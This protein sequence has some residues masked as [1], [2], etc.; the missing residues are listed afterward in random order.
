[1]AVQAHSE[2][3]EIEAVTIEAVRS[4]LEPPE[5]PCLSVYLPTHRSVPD[6]IT[7]R[8]AFGHLVEA[9]ELKLAAVRS[10][11]VIE[12][13]LNPLR[14]LA[15]DVAF[16]RHTQEGLAVLAAA[17]R[18]RVFRLQRP[19]MPLAVARPRFHTMPLVRAVTSLQRF[20]VLAITSR[21]ARIWSG[22][23]WHDPRGDVAEPLD[24]VA[25]ATAPGGEAVE[26]LSRA[27]VVSAESRE[28]HRVKH[29][30]GPSGRGGRTFVHGGFGSRHDGSDRDTE[31]FLRHVHALV[32]EEMSPRSD[33]PLVLV[34]PARL[35][36]VY[37]RLSADPLML[38]EGVDRDP[39]HLQADE[40]AA[41]VVP[42]L[43][44]RRAARVAT[45]VRSFEDARGRGRG[46]DD[47]A[48]VARAAVAGRVATVLVEADRLETG[49][50]DR[51]T[52]AIELDGRSAGD[53]SRTGD[54]PAVDRE[55]VIG[56]IVETV[57]AKG[58]AVITLPR[59]D[60][61]TRSGLAAIE[62]Y[63]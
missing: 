11:G 26:A 14:R 5:P 1:M 46:V 9:L 17:G 54:E 57:F 28:P 7:D 43:T 47:L 3:L 30:T 34:A 37:R 42:V 12:R 13:L 60:M 44:R 36:A 35:A 41:M 24:P 29:G 61:P 49:R 50:F 6:S 55:D 38:D 40:L 22:C 45:E 56:A 4:L 19:V 33:L 2:T 27:D 51:R 62:R 31:I 52:G 10:R 53:L 32:R 58:G 48:E 63:S 15:D 16:W 25:L 23:V 8:P 18:A 21:S 20:H 39:Q 59:S